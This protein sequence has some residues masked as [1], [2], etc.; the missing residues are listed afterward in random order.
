MKYWIILVLFIIFSPSILTSSNYGITTFD[1]ILKVSSLS[2]EDSFKLS[3]II[4]HN[5]KKHKINQDIFISIIKT[6]SDFNQSAISE[7][8]DVSIA[9]IN[10]KVWNKE[11]KRLGL[12]LISKNRIKYDVEYS[13]NIMGEILSIVRKRNKKDRHWFARYHSNNNK[14][15]KIY[16]AKLLNY[17]RN[18]YLSKL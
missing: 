1:K 9:Q 7:T 12:P 2:K 18:I 16:L 8:G 3:K 13:V 10:V 5:S 17:N 14:F 11:F 15:K 6:E 4:D